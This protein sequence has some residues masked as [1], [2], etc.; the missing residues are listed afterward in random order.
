MQ[1]EFKKIGYNPTETL[2][3]CLPL[4]IQMPI[5]F[6]LYRAIFVLLGSTPQALFELND[7][8]YPFVDKLVG[9]STKLPIANKFLWLNLG[10]PDPYY[11]L[12]VLIFASMFISQRLLMPPQKKKQDGKGEQ[13]DNPMAGMSQS[14]MYT[15]PLMMTFFSLSFP[16]GLSIYWILSN[17]VS[18]GQGYITRRSMSLEKEAVEARRNVPKTTGI[19]AEAKAA[20][21]GPDP[22]AGPSQSSRQKRSSKRKRRSAKR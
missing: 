4:L 16:S 11:V 3:G 1:E 15:M 10:L 7:R 9:V 2:T 14:M 18:V 12:P 5:L 19:P 8:I 13:A 6:G 22:T 20:S 21:G 17:V